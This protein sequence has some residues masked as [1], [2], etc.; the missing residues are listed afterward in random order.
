MR[1]APERGSG[2]GPSTILVEEVGT[3]TSL[4]S[5]LEFGHKVLK[6]ASNAVDFL[7]QELQEQVRA[8]THMD[9]VI[10]WMPTIILQR[11]QVSIM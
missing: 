5:E 1:I 11:L 3:T 8:L 4:M 10:S 7:T 2:K 6:I 9:L